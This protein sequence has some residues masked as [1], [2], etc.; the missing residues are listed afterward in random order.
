MRR[1]L[2]E[3]DVANL[4]KLVMDY[5]RTYGTLLK[6]LRF[7]LRSHYRA[8][9]GTNA[10]Y[11]ASATE[12]L[13]IVHQAV[14]EYQRRRAPPVAVTSREYCPTPITTSAQRCNA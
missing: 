2:T 5:E 4:C 11:I 13:L 14:A 6:Q 10:Y 8:M 12:E 1:S 3:S 9:V 7:A